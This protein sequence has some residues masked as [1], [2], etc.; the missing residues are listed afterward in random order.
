MSHRDFV[1]AEREAS[2]TRRQGVAT[3]GV[4]RQLKEQPIHM[5]ELKLQAKKAPPTS[6]YK[7]VCLGA[8]VWVLVFGCCCSLGVC[9]GVCLCVWEIAVHGVGDGSDGAAS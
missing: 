9:L 8:G 4:F 7:A 2:T 3:R 1:Q 6:Y 5:Q